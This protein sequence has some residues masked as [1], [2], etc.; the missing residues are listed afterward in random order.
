VL[1]HDYHAPSD[2]PAICRSISQ[3]RLRII[4]QGTVEHPPGERSAAL[5]QRQQLPCL[6]ADRSMSLVGRL[7]ATPTLIRV[8][9]RANAQCPPPAKKPM[10]SSACVQSQTRKAEWTAEILVSQA[11]ASNLT[12]LHRALL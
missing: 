11:G 2:T 5:V 7:A 12:Q 3:D 4:T 1:G 10:S 6:L 9:G 8:S